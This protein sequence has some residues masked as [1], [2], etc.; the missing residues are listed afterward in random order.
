MQR[1]YN[2]LLESIVVTSVRYGVNA[3]AVFNRDIDKKNTPFTQ[4]F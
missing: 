3:K 1:N 2:A 4:A